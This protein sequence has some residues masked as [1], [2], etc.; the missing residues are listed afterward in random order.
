MAVAIEHVGSTSVPGLAAKAIIDMD[1]A[2]PARD[3][4]ALATELLASLG[5]KARH[6]LRYAGMQWR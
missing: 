2:V 4:V 1:V 5:Y 6:D 3:G